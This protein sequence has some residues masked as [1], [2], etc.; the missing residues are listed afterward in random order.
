MAQARIAL[1]S[2]GLMG[3]AQQ[4]GMSLMD[5]SQLG[6]SNF[7][8]QVTYQ[9]ALEGQ[10]AQTIGQ[11]QGVSGA[12][13]QLVLPNQQDQ[14]FGDSTPSTAAVLLSDSGTLDPNSVRGIAQLVAS[15][16][17]NLSASKVTI[18]DS[19]GQLLWP[20]S[21]GGGGDGSL[22][23]K[24]SAQSRY[25][26]AMDAQVNAM[27]TQTLGPG[28][29]V[30]QV[31]ADLN[32]DQTT[33]DT[34]AYAKKGVP[35]TT[36]TDRETLTG[37]GS[38]TTAGASGSAGNIPSYAATG[39]GARSNY[40][41][42]VTDTSYGVGK[43]VTHSVVSPGAVNRQTVS[44]LFD[45]SVPAA[46]QQA[47]RTAVASAVGLNAKRG[48]IIT[49]GQMAFTKANG[50]TPAAPNKVLGY[51]KYAIVGL[52]VLLFL[53][54]VGRLVRRRES[55]ALAGEPT[56]LRELD[57]PRPL[58]AL[59]ESRLPAIPDEPTQVIPTLQAPVNVARRQVEDL[60]ER[61]STRV[62]QQVRAWMAED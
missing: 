15:S 10:L 30:A 62:A 56:W 21:D 24:Q 6:A 1:A 58:A 23:A 38:G 40:N 35:L 61:D 28:K 59:A 52:G 39:N 33:S 8:Q 41:H 42:T 54:F 12:Q 36:H 43:T 13:V 14:L 18:T 48:D 46:T 29:A 50:T 17:P 55:E 5:K 31:N 4:P 60:V 51:V 49:A 34:L 57:S 26:S 20:T 53:F 7:Q 16:V 27:L 11:I 22:L 37:T 2:A 19:T 44:L 25:D 3:S 9:R 45:Q 47:V 32:T